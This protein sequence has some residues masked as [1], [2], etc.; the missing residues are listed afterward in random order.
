MGKFFGII[1]IILTAIALIIF[2][3]VV[4][5]DMWQWFLVPL[6]VKSISTAHAIGLSFFVGLMFNLGRLTHADIDKENSGLLVVWAR[7]VAWAI[8]VALSWG[9]AAIV[10]YGYMP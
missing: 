7:L 6:G 9:C 4:L 5:V 2:K 10:H 8:A 3:G 1:A